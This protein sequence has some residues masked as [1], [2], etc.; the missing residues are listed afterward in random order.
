MVTVASRSRIFGAGLLAAALTVLGASDA[1]AQ[2]NANPRVAPPH[3]NPHG[4]SYTQWAI[5][6]WQWGFSIP[7]DQN[8]FLDPDGRFCDVGQAGSV[9][10]LGTNFGGTVVR[11]CTVPAGRALL[12]SPGSGVAFDAPGVSTEAELRAGV[13]QG[14]AGIRNVQASVDGVPLHH[15][16]TYIVES[17]LFSFTLPENNIAGAPAG[18]Y[19]GVLEGYFLLLE[20]LP[21]GHHV[22]H[23]HDEFPEFSLIS[24]IT[25]NITVR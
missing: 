5:K 25:Y 23:L 20:P 7:A 2:R 21:K 1:W 15:L 3:S 18:E 14:F 6:W 9:F 13:E 12:I 16:E 8:P 19:Q 10:F 17:P 4:M 11:T 22:I 24:D